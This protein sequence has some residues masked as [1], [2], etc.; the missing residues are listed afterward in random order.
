MKSYKLVHQLLNLVEDFEQ[1]ST[2]RELCLSDFSGFL[3]NKL[4]HSDASLT[5]LD[6]R[7]GKREAETQE[8]A[9]QI[10]NA[11][12]RLFVYMSRYAKSYIKKT[13]EGTPL[14]SPEDFTALAI[15][16]THDSL[17]KG[18]L[19]SRNIQEKTSGTEVIRRLLAA[20]LVKQWD[21]QTDKRS[22][23]ISITES[24]KQLL[25]WVFDDMNYVGKMV[26]GNLSYS[27][28]LNLQYLLQKLE[29]FHFQLH[30]DKV[31]NTKEDIRSIALNSK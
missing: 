24:G 10:D 27:E 21:D 8:L 2:G 13:L 18:E 16:L 17:T 19:I 5:S 7:F 26:T 15:L 23:R 11:I 29:A 20:G 6:A 4:E 25:H 3:I 31:I 30:E 14:Q 1:E 28:K 9:Y 12:G 22:R